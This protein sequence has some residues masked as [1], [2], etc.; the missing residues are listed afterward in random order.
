MVRLFIAVELPATVIEELQRL[1]QILQKQNL[2]KGTLTHIEGLHITLKFIGNVQSDALNNI[3]QDLNNVTGRPMQAQLGDLGVFNH[4]GHIKI[5]YAEVV[6]PGLTDLAAK[7]D[8]ALQP[9]VA[10]E[11]RE[12]VPHVTLARV[13]SA[14]NREQLKRAVAEMH[15]DHITFPI[16]QFVLK[17]SE[18]APTG[19][20]Y[21]TVATFALK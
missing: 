6:C 18:L 7:L 14:E 3:K 10:P 8:A 9:W 5:I 20:V 11:N 17:R 4:E 15:V 19:P 21:S 1:Q 2:F 16:T 13:K 12:F